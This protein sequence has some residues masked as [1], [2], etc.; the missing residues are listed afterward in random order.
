MKDSNVLIAE[1]MMGREVEDGLNPPM[2]AYL[3]N[4]GDYHHKEDLR[5]HTHW[6][7][8]LQPVVEEIHTHG[9]EIVISS[10]GVTTIYSSKGE[11]LAEEDSEEDN[12][13]HDATYKAVVTY[14]KEHWA[15]LGGTAQ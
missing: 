3:D 9:C 7:D 11:V 2:M 5:Y 15:I 10:N 1:F 12:H 13:M 8:W 14:I 4:E 6:D